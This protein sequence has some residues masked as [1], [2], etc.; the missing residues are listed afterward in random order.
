MA[1]TAK[2][3]VRDSDSDSDSKSVRPSN[4]KGRGNKEGSG[5]LGR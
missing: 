1:S 4:L 3:I 2:V 5:R